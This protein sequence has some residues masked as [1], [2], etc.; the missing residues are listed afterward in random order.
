MAHPTVSGHISYYTTVIETDM[1]VLAD[2]LED[3]I[4]GWR[5][6]KQML[7]NLD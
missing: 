7:A 1:F 5:I 3:L 4:K 6:S 2:L